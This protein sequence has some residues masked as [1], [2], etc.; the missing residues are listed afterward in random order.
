[1]QTFRHI[2]L[3]FTLCLLGSSARTQVPDSLRQQFI[4][5]PDWVKDTADTASQDTSL[6]LWE[7]TPDTTDAPVP[8]SSDSVTQAALKAAREKR[9]AKKSGRFELEEVAIIGVLNRRLNRRLRRS[10]DDATDSLALL[11]QDSL[12]LRELAAAGYPSAQIITRE[13]TGENLRVQLRPGPFY[14]YDSL[15]IDGLNRAIAD[16]VKLPKLTAEQAAFDFLGFNQRMDFV[17]RQ[18]EAR[19]Y[20]FAK[21]D[22]LRMDYRRVGDS[23]GVQISGRL[24]AGELMTVDSVMVKGDI[25][26]RPR[27]V[28][29]MIGIDR[30]DIYD[31]VRIDR[32]QRTLDNTIYFQRTEPPLVRYYDEVVTIEVETQRRKSNRF[33]ALVGLLPPREGQQRFD[34][35]G[36]AD[37]HLV[38]PFRM[39]E[40]ISLKWEKLQTSSQQ[41]D[42]SYM[43]PFLFGTN[44]NTE[45]KFHLLKQDTT[46]LRRN[47]QPTGFY[48]F[49]NE[50]SVKFFYRNAVTNLL[51]PDQ[52][53][54]VTWPPPPVLDTRTNSG[55][56]GVLYN[57]LDYRPNPTRGLDVELDIVYG[58]KNISRTQGLDS[59]EFDRL[60]PRQPRTEIDLDAS[61]YFP[62]F[63]R[64]VLALRNQTY[65]LNL[66]EYLD[67][68]QQFIGGARSLRGFNENQF[69]ASFYSIMSLEYRLLLDPDSYLG[70]FVD[71]S[72]LEYTQ[73]T[74]VTRLWPYGFGLALSFRT[75]AGIMSVSYALGTAGDVP[76]QPTR[77]RIHLGLVNTF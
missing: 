5:V 36:L 51:S 74:D 49:N 64:Q 35:T 50:L 15:N 68:D 62:T 30:G 60:L 13:R 4:E 28:R 63:D 61:V 10:Y 58:Q 66:R 55:G 76:L 9:V 19:G 56:V 3:V 43:Q 71:A 46:F 18:F 26:E 72:V 11:K 33:D 27:F 25:R 38:S 8:S 7:A 39:G 6:L 70:A 29:R 23:I 12:A 42:V 69:L 20:P 48:R 59:L 44:F 75:G 40:V 16:Q 34:F 53:S 47:F 22:D 1:M 54:E 73:L 77:G 45:L 52:F 2:A 17:L 65:W 14:F 41:L 67:N 21:L 37:L 31:Q 32:I 24:N 57:T